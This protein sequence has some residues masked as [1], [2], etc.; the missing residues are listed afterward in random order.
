[1]LENQSHEIRRLK[2]ENE[3]LKTSTAPGNGDQA[4]DSLKSPEQNEKQKTIEVEENQH[5]QLP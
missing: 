5:S 4:E 2:E 3:R 1:M